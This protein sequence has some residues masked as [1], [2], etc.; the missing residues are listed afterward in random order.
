MSKGS[1]PRPCNKQRFDE[2]YARVFSPKRL[3]V[4]RDA[5]PKEVPDGIQ[6]NT[7]DGT[8][9]RADSGRIA[10]VPQE[11][12]G[13]LDSQVEGPMASPPLRNRRAALDKHPLDTDYWTYSGYQ[14][15][16]T[17]PHGVGHGNHIHGCCE[18]HCCTR[19]DFPLRETKQ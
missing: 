14:G 16:F 18:E 17:C 15:E 4:W 7:G 9:D 1:R 19:A 11:P 3:N 10:Q 8:R 13:Q 5:P 6:G 12:G 2:N